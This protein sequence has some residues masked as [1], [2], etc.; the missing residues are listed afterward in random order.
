MDLF[1]EVTAGNH[2]DVLVAALPWDPR[3]LDNKQP[4]ETKLKNEA[5]VES[6]TDGLTFGICSVKKQR[7]FQAKWW[8]STCRQT[9][10]NSLFNI[11]RSCGESILT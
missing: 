4:L 7:M 6:A 3:A 1:A 9:T 10:Q 5:I 8:S 11:C 2:L